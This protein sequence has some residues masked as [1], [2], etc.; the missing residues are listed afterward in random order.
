MLF[1]IS[2]REIADG[3]S[4][5]PRPILRVERPTQLASLEQVGMRL[6]E[7]RELLSRQIGRAHV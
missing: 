5:E 2:V 3:K 4:D 6:A 1:E 7:G